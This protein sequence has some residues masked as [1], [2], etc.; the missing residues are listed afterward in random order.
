LNANDW[1]SNNNNIPRGKAHYY[2]PGGNIGGPVPFTKDKL[3]FWFGYEK[4]IQ[5]TGNATTLTSYIPT[6]DMLAGNFTATPANSALCPTGFSATNTGTYCNNLQGTVLPDGSII[7]VSPNRPVGIIPSQFLGTAAAKDGKAL[8]SI[9]PAPNATPTAANNYENFI[10]A[11]PGVDNG[12]LFRVRVDYNFSD[13]TKIYASYQYATDSTPASGGGAHIYWTPGNSIPFPGGALT[14]VN[15]SYVFSGHFI[16]TFSNTLTNEAIAS[17]GN[18]HNATVVPNV[19]ALTRSATGY[20][21]GTIF[22]NG[23][24]LIPAYSSAGNQTF[25]DHSQ[26]DIFTNGSYS[27]FKPQPSLADNLI[28]VWGSHTVKTGVFYE[29]VDNNQGGFNTP[30]G[31]AGFG[32]GGNVNKNAVTGTPQGSPN[33]PLANLL[34]GNATSY[35]ENSANPN[36]DLAFKVISFYLDDAWKATR[37]MSLEYGLRFDHIG[38]WYD[39]GDAGIPVFLAARVANDFASGIVNPGL[40]YHAINSAVP[41]SGIDSTFLLMSPRFGVSYDVFGTGNTLVRGGIGAYRFGDNWGDYSGG[42]SLAQGVLG[43]SLPGS[44]SVT[45]DQIGASSAPALTPKGA[46]SGTIQNAVDPNDHGNPTTYAYNLTISQRIPFNSLLEISYVGNQSKQVLVGGGS[47]A[48]LGSG[49]PYINV[50]KEPLGVLFKPDP[51]TGITAPNPENVTQDLNGNSLPNKPADYRPYGYAYGTNAVYVMSHA[52]YSN[53]NGLQVSLVKRSAHLSMN[54]NYTHSKSLGTDLQEDPFS[55][56]GNYGVESSDRPNVF[57]ASFSYNDL[58]VYH[59]G[60]RLIAGATNNWLISAI[61]TYQGGGNLQAINGNPNPNFSFS[62]SYTGSMP[63]GVGTAISGA[64]YFGTDAGVTIMPT[65]T[66]N[67]KSGLKANQYVNGSC[68]GV[69]TIGTNGPRNYPYLS[70]PAYFDSDLA[71]AKAFHI[72][73]NHTVTFRASAFD[74]LNHPINAFSGNQL[75]LYFNTN[76]ASK[77]STLSAQTVPTFGTTVLKAGGDQRRIIELSLKYAF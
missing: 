29:M 2:Y 44:N 52:G 68:F 26:Q 31:S 1:Q 58:K 22:N 53:Y 72:T 28:K 25:P 59:G 56:R 23:D 38:R 34:L 66:C 73:E 13:H 70:G 18:A 46:G 62:N 20:V 49:S 45:L 51:V 11:V 39:R 35:S 3:L 12:Y 24:P 14:S 16:H 71:L 19:S 4:F 32:T 41:K 55:L 76:Y 47:S 64:T 6:S 8:A 43:Y 33:N 40:Q 10:L 21:G 74:W 69:P 30:N 15:K 17:L 54:L 57:N 67:P 65:L 61:T 77:A 60:N 37:R 36:Q 50:N 63:S 75:K 42:L 48:T 27:L 5:N 9:W 7:G